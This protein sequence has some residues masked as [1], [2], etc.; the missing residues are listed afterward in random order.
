[1]LSIYQSNRNIIKIGKTYL[2]VHCIIIGGLLN[3]SAVIYVC[4]NELL[5]VF[6]HCPVHTILHL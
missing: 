2:G 4:I 3:R 6:T 1:M 5:N